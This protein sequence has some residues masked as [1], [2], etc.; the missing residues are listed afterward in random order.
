MSWP[1]LSDLL[2]P[3]DTRSPIGLVGAPA[4]VGRRAMSERAAALGG[5]LHLVGTPGGGLT[6]RAVLPAVVR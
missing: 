6:V 5:T 1:N 2:M 4:G 3:A